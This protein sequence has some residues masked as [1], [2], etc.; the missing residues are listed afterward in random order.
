MVYHLLKDTLTRHKPDFSFHR[1]EIC[2]AW[3][4]STQAVYTTTMNSIVL[5]SK[6]YFVFLRRLWKHFKNWSSGWT[7]VSLA[8]CNNSSVLR[9][10]TTHWSQ[11]FRGSRKIRRFLGVL[12][13]F[14]HII[15]KK[16]KRTLHQLE[17]I[18]WGKTAAFPQIPLRTFQ[19]PPPP[20]ST[21]SQQSWTLWLVAMS[22]P[23]LVV[24]CPF[25]GSSKLWEP[26]KVSSNEWMLLE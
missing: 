12:G 13:L 26:N 1:K 10:P 6:F 17:V 8:Y 14:G 7:P 16:R 25:P 3:E 21:A 11:H 18:R 23:S 15:G 4:V 9:G 19:G 20:P 24:S 5:K 2:E 22:Q